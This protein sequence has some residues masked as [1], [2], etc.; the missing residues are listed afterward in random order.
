MFKNKITVFLEAFHIRLFKHEMS[1]E[2]KRFLKNLSWSLLGGVSAMLILSIINIIAG[3]LMG[4]IEYGKYN[5]V[6][7]LATILSFFILL[8]NNSGSIRYITD[9]KLKIY[10]GQILSASLL[11]FVFQFLIVSLFYVIIFNLFYKTEFNYLFLVFIIGVTLAIKEM[12]DS[13]FRSFGMFKL[14]NFTKIAD[15]FLVL[16]VFIFFFIIKDNIEYQKYAFSIISGSILFIIVGIFKILPRIK[17]IE[18]KNIKL[19]L[20]YNKF[21]VL[22]SASGLLIGVDKIFIGRFIGTGVLGIYSAYFTSSQLILSSLLIIFMNIFWPAVIKNKEN[23]NIILDKI[24]ILF[25]KHLPFWW[26][27]NSLSIL[28]FIYLFGSQYPIS[29]I[30]IILFSLSSL[31]NII[32]SIMINLYNIDKIYRSVLVAFLGYGIVILSIPVFKSVTVYLMFQIV[33]Y[34]IGSFYISNNLKKTSEI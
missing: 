3:R 21:M 10:K 26:I 15:A 32:F 25:F 34:M 19:L 27:L 33:I 13:Y 7:S 5:Y 12:F 23:M 8:G 30:L 9:E 17:N 1:E 31:M 16:A 24:H 4:P 6:L 2:M 14:Q 20:N 11:I 28:F 18:W 22:V 29:L